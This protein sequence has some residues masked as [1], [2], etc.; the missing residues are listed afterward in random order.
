MSENQ[1]P[2]V[3]PSI[4]HKNDSQLWLK[5]FMWRNN[6]IL[7]L[8]H[9]CPRI[10]Q[11]DQQ[12][13]TQMCNLSICKKIWEVYRNKKD[14]WETYIYPMLGKCC[15]Y[16]W[17][18]VRMNTNQVLEVS[19]EWKFFLPTMSYVSLEARSWEDEAHGGH[20]VIWDKKLYREGEFYSRI[21]RH[22]ITTRS[23]YM[24]YQKLKDDKTILKSWRQEF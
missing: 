12:E 16:I 9:V 17:Y 23:W 11:L 19:Y 1:F 18:T 22:Q 13:G 5:Y 2:M 3:L 10:Q 24:L 14:S 8:C 6:H 15:R 7:P 4:Q 20:Q 21:S